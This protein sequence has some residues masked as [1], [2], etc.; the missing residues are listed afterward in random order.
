MESISALSSALSQ[1]QT[2][3]KVQ[4]AVFRKSL[5]AE[6]GAAAGLIQLIGTPQPLATEGALG[7][8][9]NIYG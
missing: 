5:D 7:T 3:A 1:I 9:L 2:E 6:A 8:R 4:T